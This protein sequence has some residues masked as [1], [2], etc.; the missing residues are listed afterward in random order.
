[1]QR[2][3]RPDSYY[4][5]VPAVDEK[6]GL[7]AVVRFDARFGNYQQ[8][9]AVRD[10]QASFFGFGEA[11][12]IIEYLLSKRLELPDDGGRLVVRREALCVHPCLVWRPCR[13]SLSPFYPFR[14]ISVGELRLF[15]RIFD[16]AIF[17]VLTA[18]KG[19][20]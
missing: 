16:G 19:G 13:Q 1:V 15:V 17:F 18:D 5:I 6:G 10:P 20:I 12:E 3:D 11:E 2:L 4:W 14:M 8:A 9:I 7:R